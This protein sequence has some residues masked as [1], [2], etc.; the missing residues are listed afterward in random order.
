MNCPNLRPTCLDEFVG[1]KE[2]KENL[3][4]YICSAI[5]RKVPLDHILLHGLPGTGKTSLATVIANEMKSK[6]KIVQGNTL[7]RNVDIINLTLSL[8]DGDTL[9]ID[10]IHAINPQIQEL[11]YSIMEDFSIDITLGKDFNAKP[12]RVSVPKFTLIGATTQLGKISQPLEQR[13]GIV[14]NLKEYDIESLIELIQ[15][16]CVKL[17]ISLS[18]SDCKK[19]AQNS[20]GIPRNANNLLK[21]I[22][23]FKHF[24]R[25]MTVDTILQKL[26]IFK[27]GLTEDDLFYLNTL[28]NSKNAIGLKTLAQI[29]GSDENTIACKTEPF[30]LT[31]G[32]ISKTSGGRIINDKGVELLK[33]MLSLADTPKIT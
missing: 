25:S 17:K 29:I 8:S 11:L 20:K 4:I 26:R 14:I 27:H 15:K 13:F 23:D 2:I 10:E 12:T 33:E 18:K 32:Y 24:D 7:Q 3:K 31:N 6:L 1:K 5:K 9:F 19:I 21:R 16:S 22:M 30:L 28:K